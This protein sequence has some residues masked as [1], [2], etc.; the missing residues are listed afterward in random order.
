MYIS[1]FYVLTQFFCEKQIFFVAYA[2]KTKKSVAKRF[3]LLPN[4]VIFT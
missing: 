3:I 2:K 1:I 4:F